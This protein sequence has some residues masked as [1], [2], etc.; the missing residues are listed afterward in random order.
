MSKIYCFDYPK[1]PIMIYYVIALD[2]IMIY[3][4]I[5]PGMRL[6]EKKKKII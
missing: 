2:L 1:L 3:Y 4:I 6:T 5:G